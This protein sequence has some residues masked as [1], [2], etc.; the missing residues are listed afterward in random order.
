M[1]QKHDECP[2]MNWSSIR[3]I[4]LKTRSEVKMTRKWYATLHHPMMHP[5]TKF[6]ISYLKK[7]RRYVPDTII[8]KSWSQ[9]KGYTCNT[10]RILR[11]APGFE[12]NIPHFCV[13]DVIS[14]ILNFAIMIL[15][16]ATVFTAIGT[17]FL[18]AVHNGMLP[19]TVR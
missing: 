2:Q 18:T 16:H 15:L 14:R 12:P 17:Q 11:E 8:L 1:L 10:S 3:H 7:Y 6:G 5:Q 9:V 13:G 4:F 19:L